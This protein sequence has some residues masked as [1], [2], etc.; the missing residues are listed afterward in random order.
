V[1]VSVVV[2]SRDRPAALG[3]CLAAL[4]ALEQDVPL[5]IVVVDDG[6]RDEA[7]VAAVV[8]AV[9][10]ARVVRTPGL[11][12]GA[13]RNAGVRAATGDVVLFT[14]D[15]CRPDPGW[16]RLLVAA[17]AR[18]G[19]AAAGGRT[20][21]GDPANAYARVSELVCGFA[22][23]RIGFLIGNNIACRRDVALAVPFD[24]T[25][26]V[27]AGEDREW[28]ARLRANGHRIA[29]EPDAVVRHEP[30]LD[31]RRFWAQHVRYGQGSAWLARQRGPGRQPVAFYAALLRRGFRTGLRDG[32]L[33]CLAELATAVGYVQERRR[34]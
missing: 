8:A 32:L 31:L 30:A 19:T 7:G 22:R 21:P 5:E 26:P 2:P 9:P 33:L 12:L 28:S 10:A 11:G 17:V 18:D 24:E 23:E 14:D 4:A 25:S 1:S 15:D 29:F 34:V 27:P 16:A 6:S 3:R 20:V 13:A